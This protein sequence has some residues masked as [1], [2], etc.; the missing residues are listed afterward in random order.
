VPLISLFGQ[1]LCLHCSCLLM[2]LLHKR[3]ARAAVLLVLQTCKSGLALLSPRSLAS[4]PDVEAAAAKP[5]EDGL[6]CRHLLCKSST[7]GHKATS[8]LVVEKA[9]MRCS[10]LIKN[11]LT[12]GGL[13]A[14]VGGTLVKES[15]ATISLQALTSGFLVKMAL[16]GRHLEAMAL[17]L[18]QLV[19]CPLPI[20]VGAF[21]AGA[22]PM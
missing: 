17:V 7:F 5:Q 10:L 3:R 4:K 21:H 20:P 22:S 2:L 11:P 14:F 1:S 8:S 6:G 19:D 13:L 16:T 12:T 18:P 9:P 15:L